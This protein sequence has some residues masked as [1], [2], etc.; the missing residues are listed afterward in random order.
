MHPHPI[1]GSTVGTLE[2]SDVCSVLGIFVRVGKKVVF[3]IDGTV[4]GSSVG[5]LEGIRVGTS[6]GKNV[7]SSVGILVGDTVTPDGEFVGS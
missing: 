7:G 5:R 2:G 1:V 6:E 3:G 4:E